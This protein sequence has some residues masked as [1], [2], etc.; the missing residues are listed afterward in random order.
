MARNLVFHNGKDDLNLTL[1]SNKGPVILYGAT[2]WT[3]YLISGNAF[4][5]DY[6]CDRLAFGTID[7]PCLSVFDV[8]V[9][10]SEWLDKVISKSGERATIIICVGINR[11]TIFEI[12]HT[13]VEMDLNADLYD[14][15]VQEDVFQDTHFIYKGNQYALFEHPFNCGFHYSRMTERSVEMALALK[16]MQE[17]DKIMEIGVVTPYYLGI[18]TK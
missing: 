13:L 10:K 15:F 9:I 1:K 7:N 5:V 2:I 11:N 6:V 17:H 3:A 16:W 4:H 12:F 14:Y 8:P 18:V